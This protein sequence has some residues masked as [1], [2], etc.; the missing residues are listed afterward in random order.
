VF[1]FFNVFFRNGNSP[2][3]YALIGHSSSYYSS[4]P[5][6]PS[7]PVPSHGQASS[8]IPV[9]PHTVYQSIVYPHNHQYH[10][11]A[12]HHTDTRAPLY[13]QTPHHGSSSIYRLSSGGSDHPINRQHNQQNHDQLIETLHSSNTSGGVAE[14]GNTL[15]GLTGSPQGNSGQAANP[16]ADPVSPQQDT[17][18]SLGRTQ[19]S[20]DSTVW[21]PY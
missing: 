14:I 5:S 11:T 6:I 2:T 3:T 1:L 7:V 21:R 20:T 15:H 8:G 4:I 9:A 13:A 10:H 19:S 17:N 12:I 18:D 16:S